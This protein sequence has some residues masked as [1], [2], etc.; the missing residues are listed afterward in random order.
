MAEQLQLRRGSTAANDALTG[1]AGELTVDTTLHQLRLHDG[2]TAGGHTIGGGGGDALTTDPLSQF[3]A[4]TSA[5]L[6]GVISD[7]TGTGSLVF[8]TSPTLVTPALGTPASGTLTNCTGLPA[9]GVSG[10]ALVSAAIGTTV[11]A[12]DADLA[13]LAGLTS[14]ADKGIQFTGAGTAATYDLTTAG[15]ALLDDASS[16]AQ[17]TTL[18]FSAIYG[19]FVLP[20]YHD[21]NA[22]TLTTHPSTAQFLANLNRLLHRADLT[23]WTEARLVARVTAGSASAN[24]PRLVLRYRTSF[25]TTVGDYVDAGTSE[26]SVSLASTGCP[27]GSWG[28]LAA[29]A[30]DDVYISVQQIGG[31][32]SAS[33]AIAGV[34]VE[35]RRAN[36]QVT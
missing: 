4:T 16:S 32:S 26:I 18:G 1:A 19:K 13:A 29:G 10:T 25:S 6:R 5:Q 24:N 9:A 36:Y 35:F 12:Y 3:A 30:K 20:I 14:A 27:A 34:W 2:S 15:K 11:Q 7:E 8:A 21:V 17:R 22:S 23:D 33:P 28:T 31:D